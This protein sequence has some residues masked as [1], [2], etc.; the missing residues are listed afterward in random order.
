[1]LRLA[2]LALLST[3]ACSG[4]SP[5][6]ASLTLGAYTTPR[7]AYAAIVPTF[8]REW[9]ART[10]DEVEVRTSFSG[11]G[12][13]ARAIASGFEA[14]VAALSL[15]PDIQTLVDAQLVGGGW[16]RDAHGG[17]VTRSVV[18]IGVRAG[19]PQGIREWSDL[20]RP[21]L[22]VLTPNVRTSGGA[23]WNVLAV[24]GAAR[25]SV[26]RL[27]GCLGCGGSHGFGARLVE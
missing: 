16:S 27:S 6:S 21:G 3:L 25:R 23:M 10:G 17:I 22:E 9:R 24:V 14:D 1:M 13:Q 11:S 20:A 8:A 18:V 4:D 26:L 7:E 5:G 19:N 2:L 15:E 12:A